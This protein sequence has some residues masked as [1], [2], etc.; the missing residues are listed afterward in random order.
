MLGIALW[1]AVCNAVWAGDLAAFNAAVDAAA[2]HNRVAIGYLRT[3]NGDLAGLEIDRLRQAWSGVVERFS[4]ERPDVFNNNPLYGTTLTAVSTRLVAADL[5]L[6]TGRLDAARQSL[7]GVRADLYRLRQ[8]AGVTVLADCIL[9]SNQA[10]AAFMAYD[11]RDLDWNAADT[12]DGIAAT[13]QAYGKVLERC[14]VIAGETLRREPEFRRLID[15]ARKDL[16]RVPQ[17]IA[18]RDSALLHRVVI[19]LRAIDNLLSFRFG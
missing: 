5:M 4:G 9:E 13:S 1:G 2:A 11:K 6:N 19:S 18:I 12:R 15:D 14:D 17:A 16:A 8:S 7:N 10:A 3:G